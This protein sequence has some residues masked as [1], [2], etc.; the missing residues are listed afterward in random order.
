M[1][2]LIDRI[3]T[4]ENN[5]LRRNAQVT[6]RQ[7]S[8][9]QRSKDGGYR[10]INGDLNSSHNRNDANERASSTLSQPEDSHDRSRLRSPL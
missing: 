8:Y 9:A 10:N 7:N 4:Y 6:N 2:S 1:G 5:G 3:R